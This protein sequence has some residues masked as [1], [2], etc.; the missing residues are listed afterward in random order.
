MKARQGQKFKNLQLS[1]SVILVVSIALYYGFYPMEI[2]PGLFDFKADSDDLKGI[3]TSIMTLYF[4]MSA[5]WLVGIFDAGFWRTAT[6]VNVIFMASLSLGRIMAMLLYG[7]PSDCFTI[8]T[9]AELVLAFWGFLNL[10][11]YGQAIV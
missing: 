7:L 1:V 4:G 10:R 5:L 6:L 2:F 3:L 9:S 11:K 8:G